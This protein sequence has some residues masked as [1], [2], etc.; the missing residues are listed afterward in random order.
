MNEQRIEEIKNAVRELLQIIV[1]RGQPLSD[2]LKTRLAQVIEHVTNR[3]Q[4][5]RQVEPPLP[6]GTE[7]LWHLANGNVDAFVNYLRTVPD[8]ALNQL[9]ANP[10][11]LQSVVQSLS[12]RFPQAPPEQIGGVEQAPINSSNIWGF[13]YEPRSQVLRVRFQGDGIYQYQGVPP[14]I[15]QIF[16][17][18]AVPAKTTGSNQY[19]SWW[20]GKQPSLGAALFALI[21][22]G[23]YP[24]QKVA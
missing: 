6:I 12:Q 5:L 1:T 22:N 17:A 24:Y 13:S 16:Q 9:L 11:Q 18:G 3:I 19:G 21:K 7:L 14:Y 20:R 23:G 4:E 8:P 2:E 10:T 15:F